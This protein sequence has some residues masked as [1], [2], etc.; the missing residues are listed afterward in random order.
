LARTG[1]GVHRLDRGVHRNRE[2]KWATAVLSGRQAPEMMMRPVAIALVLTGSMFVMLVA[3]LAQQPETGPGKQ[4]S[5][6]P[7]RS[8]E[9]G[10]R[11]PSG[12]APETGYHGPRD[13][14]KD[15]EPGKAKSPDEL[16]QTGQSPDPSATKKN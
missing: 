7:L 13:V 16:R 8:G 11:G 3:A 5:D 15:A 4:G 6:A 10:T 1:F 14:T 2:L 9:T 12:G